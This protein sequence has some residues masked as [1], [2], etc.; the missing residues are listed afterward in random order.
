M[1]GKRELRSGERTGEKREGRQVSV[2]FG[3]LIYESIPEVWS[4]QLL[5]A[6]VMGF[7]ASAFKTMISAVT[8]TTG[9][10]ITTANLSKF[11]LNWRMPVL[12][13]LG[14]AL[15]LCY[16]G[17]ELFALIYLSDDI[18]GGRQ[19]GVRREMARGFRALRRF[20]SPTGALVLLYVFIAVPLAGVGFSISLTSTFR[21]PN[22][23][24]DVVLKTP[25]Y[26]TAYFALVLALVWV[27]V[28]YIFVLHGVLL[29]GLTPADAR[30]SS[31]RIMKEHKK[32]FIFGIL[33]I[34]IL[35]ELVRFAVWLLFT[36]MPGVFAGYAGTL[37]PHDVVIDI[38][39]DEMPAGVDA[40]TV[41]AILGYRIYSAL[42]VL[43]GAY[44]NA[45]MLMVN[46]ALF[47]VFFTRYYFKY[48]RGESVSWPER[49][50]RSRY[51]WKFLGM[52]AMLALCVALA[53]G[54]GLF[55]DQ[56]GLQGVDQAK[57]VAHRA[58]GTMASENSIEGLEKAIEHKC[59]ASE[60]DVQRTADGYYV[61][62][63]DA[64]FA[65][66][67]GVARA[68]KDMT[69]DEIRQLRIKDTTGNGAELPVVTLEEMLPVIKDRIKLF[70]E[71]KGVTAD[72]QMAD[73]VVAL[74]RKYDCVNDVTLISLEYDVIDYAES[75]YP[76][77]ETGVLFFAGLGDVSRLN[78]DL[79]IMEEE[80]G[81][82]ERVQRIHASGKQAIVW[83]VNTAESMNVFLDRSRSNVDAIITDEIE[84]AE[85]VRRQLDSRTEYQVFQS[86]LSNAFD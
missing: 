42:V 48:T 32:D 64:D 51:I 59:Y 74:V 26:A 18:L 69:M 55:Y 20:R 6:M 19:G 73:D 81:S 43:V 23:I 60:I 82:E 46:G 85:S 22:F 33:K 75:T 34:F 10:A 61:I 58:G 79:L 45:V 65:R 37:L 86:L 78:C 56:L 7:I 5:A 84:L 66:L 39:A 50:K 3:R 62:N 57:L 71:L 52:M 70:I 80:M 13:A 9:T 27:G 44:F 53:V 28:R 14:F 11:L 72:R 31:A 29:D 77:F 41:A 12:L 17:M 30:R 63:H 38:T 49:P 68:P 4:F 36:A 40:A 15:V 67:T 54:F 21:I 35:M 2:T 47:M 83:T 24:M 8:A 25:L 1:R 16:I 76:E